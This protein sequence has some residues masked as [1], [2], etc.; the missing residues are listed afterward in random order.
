MHS[1]K[2]MERVAN[3]EMKLFEMQDSFTESGSHS[4]SQSNASRSISQSQMSTHKFGES[5]L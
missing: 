2:L 1:Q 4:I 3:A 5:I